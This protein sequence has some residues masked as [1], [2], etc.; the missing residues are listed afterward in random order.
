MATNWSISRRTKACA[1]TERPFEDG[2]RHASF[3]CTIDGDLERVDLCLDA[4]RARVE[5]GHNGEE[6]LFF[7]FTRHEESR[8]KTVQMDI[9]SL[10]RLFVS[11]EGREETSVRELRYVLCLLLMR[12]RRAK[13]EK[14][15]RDGDV[16]SFL[17]KRPK[18]DTRY[19][20]F[21]Y[22]FEP[23]R[24]DQVRTQLQAVF[25]GADGP[26]GIRLGADGEPGEGAAEGAAPESTDADAEADAPSEVEADDSTVA[27]EPVPGS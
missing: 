23:E 18:D 27:P 13:M 20:V 1:D 9:E 21:V 17:V 19:Q 6:P 16:E 4:W 25:D 12:K 22:D 8:K 11:L 10:D 15:V 24:L 14:V 2:E 26:E 3:L 5:R 7:W